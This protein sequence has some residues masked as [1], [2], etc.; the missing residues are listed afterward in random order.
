VGLLVVFLDLVVGSSLAHFF[1]SLGAY[2]RYVIYLSYM[3]NFISCSSFSNITKLN[4][5]SV[6]PYNIFE[7]IEDSIE[8]VHSYKF[9]VVPLHFFMSYYYVAIAMRWRLRHWPGQ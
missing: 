3:L 8:E 2:L 5:A 4:Y 1:L 6:H 7:M 9:V